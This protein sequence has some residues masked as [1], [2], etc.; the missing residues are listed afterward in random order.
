MGDVI[1]FMGPPGAGKGTQADILARKLGGVH[2]STGDILRASKEPRLLAMM[3][4]GKLV[5]SEDLIRVTQ[6]ALEAVPVEKPIIFDGG[7]RKLPEAEYWMENLPKMNR[8]LKSVIFLDVHEEESVK[9]N[10]LRGRKDDTK[11]AMNVRFA[12]YRLDTEPVFDY[13]RKLGLLKQVDGIGSIEEV[14]RRVEAAL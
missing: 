14:A 7:S 6:S 4:S 1:V 10:L 8:H 13:Y 3:E 9:R 5:D 12:A 11:E 2:L